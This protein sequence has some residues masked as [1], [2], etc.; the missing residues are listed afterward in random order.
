[1]IRTIESMSHTIESMHVH[2][3]HRQVKLYHKPSHSKE[4]PKI[5]INLTCLANNTCVW[6]ENAIVACVP[7]FY[8]LIISKHRKFNLS[9]C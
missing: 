9:E 8:M 4:H 3:W 1:M 2:A 5:D 6:G 7:D